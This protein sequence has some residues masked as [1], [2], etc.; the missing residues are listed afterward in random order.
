MGPLIPVLIS[1]ALKLLEPFLKKL[2]DLAYREIEEWANREEKETGVKVPSSAKIQGA[3]ARV[4][5]AR[6]DIDPETARVLIEAKHRKEQ[7]KKR[8]RSGKTAGRG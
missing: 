5:A 3:V 4:T 8:K 1:L 6:P 2:I 7:R